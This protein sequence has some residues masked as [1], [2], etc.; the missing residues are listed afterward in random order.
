[1]GIKFPGPATVPPSGFLLCC[2]Y[3]C[4]EVSL[5]FDTIQSLITLLAVYRFLYRGKHVNER[6]EV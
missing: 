4:G 3:V 5:N 2:L 1:M 6:T